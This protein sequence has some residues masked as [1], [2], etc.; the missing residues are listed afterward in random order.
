[1]VHGVSLLAGQPLY[2]RC[3]NLVHLLAGVACKTHL[4]WLEYIQHVV[5]GIDSNALCEEVNGFF[6]VLG[7]K[8]GIALGLEFVRRHCSCVDRKHYKRSASEVVGSRRAGK[9]S[10]YQATGCRP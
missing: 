10:R 8:G 6:V 5:A 4:E 1:M 2:G 9:T 7:H 3:A